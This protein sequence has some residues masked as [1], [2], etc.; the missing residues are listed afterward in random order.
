V[1]AGVVVELLTASRATIGLAAAGYAGLFALS[2]LRHWTSRKAV[3]A[4]IG[5]AVIAV[6][7]PLA[8]SVVQQRGSTEIESSDFERSSF[9]AAAEAM[10]LR[11]PFGVGANNYVVVA[12][13]EG[14]NAAA[15][16]PIVGYAGIVHNIY[17][18]IAAETGYFGLF[19]FLLLLIRPMMVAFLCGWRN[20]RDP[21]GDLLL[22]IG[23]A[24]L[25]VYIH[26]SFEWVL[27]S[28]LSQYMLAIEIGMVAGLAEQLG[29][30][31]KAYP[32]FPSRVGTSSLQPMKSLR[33][34]R[35]GS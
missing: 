7:A 15:G 10:I 35:D 8:L 19:A 30:W 34:P 18:L 28:Y 33:A 3:L 24:L 25:I 29:Y 17:L 13:L 23:V 32:R 14:F 6:L 4:L 5:G 21:R 20:R 1:F 31:R 12:N 11:H 22:G 26:S 16:V 27:I 9:E 2:A